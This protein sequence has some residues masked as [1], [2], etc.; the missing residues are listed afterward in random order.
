MKKNYFLSSLFILLFA[1]FNP[2]SA[3]TNFTKNIITKVSLSGKVIAA[4]TGLPLQSASIYIPDLKSGTTTDA[5]GNYVLHNIPVGTYLIQVDFVGYQTMVKR[6]SLT[7]NTTSDFAL[8]ISVTEESEIVITGSSRATTIR[9][10]PIPIVSISKQ[11][12]QQNLSTNII[13]AIA[14][15]P[16][17]SAVTTGPNISKPFIRGL[18]FNRILTL[19]DGVRQ[20]GQQ[21]GDEHGIEVD[22]NTVDKVEVVTGPASLIYGSDA[23][24]G[25]VNLLPPNP[26]A[27]GKTIGNISGE[28][29]TNNGL[30]AGSAM[31]AGNKKSF[32]WMGRASY[33]TATNYRNK[34]DGRVF[35]TGF[36]ELD[37]S[38]SAGIN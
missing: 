26:P 19:Y 36:R 30:M 4:N 10:N 2:A 25:V 37:F 12:L 16:G 21:W 7:E 6:I 1:T 33:K 34:I 13:D 11:Y 22:Q 8:E 9:R 29:Q 5:N 15:V 18:G 31:M 28:Y 3:Q 35:N 27:E 14:R 38:G 17:V 23:V 32:T 20:E 24:A